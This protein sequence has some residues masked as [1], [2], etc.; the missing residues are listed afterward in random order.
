MR[1]ILLLLAAASGLA[2]QDSD[3]RALVAAAPRLPVEKTIV[4]PQPPAG[5]SGWKIGYP[6]SVTLAPDGTVYLLQ[7]DDT[8]DPV[9][10]MTRE[11]RFLRSWGKG[12]YKIPHA[13]RI[14][15]RGD[16]WTVDAGNSMIYRFDT[17]GRKL[18]EISVGEQP[19]G[20]SAFTGTTDIA[21]APN[22]HLYIS[23]GYGNARILEYS[24]DGKRLNQWGSPGSGP[25]QFRQPHGV[26]VDADG[27]VYVA[28][29][30]NGRLQRFDP[31]G[32]YL[33]EWDNLGMVT[34][35]AIRDGG[36]WIG[37]QVRTDPT[38]A[39][40]WLMRIDPK[41]GR[42]LG[43]VESAHGHHVLNVTAA[44]DLL[45]GARPDTVL[46]FRPAS[47][48]TVSFRVQPLRPVAELREA[49]LKD[50]PP[51]ERPGLRKP[52]LVDLATLGAQIH[53]DIRYATSNNFLGT[54]LYAEARAFLE[55]PAA[56]ALLQAAA[57]LRKQGFG[58]LIHDAYRPWYV[59]KMFWDGTP[60]EL[61][62]FVADP[63][64][65]SKHNRGCAVDLSIY[66]LDSGRPVEMPSGY[67]EMT[68]RAFPD[69]PGGT[70]D[71]RTHRAALRHAMESHGFQ[72]DK[73][74][75][76]HYDYRDWPRYPIV[77]IPFDKL[78]IP[79]SR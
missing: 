79:A 38:S 73:A 10:A 71:E 56:H 14:D 34:T 2:G 1:T 16:I 55:R 66:Y 44:G 19:T 36:L 47:K 52:D 41:S 28:D 4:P 77:N 78:G 59:T 50:S 69:Y 22:G 7:R 42:I 24:A 29:R 40:G 26:A 53:F 46:W 3:L 60:P 68:E 13:I 76:W 33:G 31:K 21:F 43:T 61:H 58:L 64:K 65:G 9:I 45:S 17:Q 15:P 30:L 49:A 25:G 51:A 23:D 6:S 67:D 8:A 63:S 18:Q 62:N 72:V 74:E 70:P 75:W 54:P 57:D 37:T 48:E 12:L 11:G 32:K 20:A 5:A 39:D 27:T 35:V